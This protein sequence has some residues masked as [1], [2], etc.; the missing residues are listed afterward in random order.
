VGSNPTLSATSVIIAHLSS[1]SSRSLQQTFVSSARYAVGF[2]E[3][4]W[5]VRR[6][7]L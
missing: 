6:S 2:Y 5:K 4:A 3:V 7:V 1:T